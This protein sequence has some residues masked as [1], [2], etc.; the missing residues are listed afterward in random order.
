MA[1]KILYASLQV[2]LRQEEQVIITFDRKQ[3]KILIKNN[4]SLSRF[5]TLTTVHI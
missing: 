1:G 5:I 4:Y 2:S 3:S